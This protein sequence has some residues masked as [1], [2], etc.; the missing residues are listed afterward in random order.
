MQF[1]THTE[2]YYLVFNITYTLIGY[3][4]PPPVTISVEACIY[5]YN[6]EALRLCSISHIHDFFNTTI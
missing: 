4:D 2:L 5:I 6:Y 3:K 1:V